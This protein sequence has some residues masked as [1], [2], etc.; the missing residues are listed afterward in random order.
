MRSLLAVT[1]L[2]MLA[3]TTALLSSGCSS[4]GTQPYAGP[5]SPAGT[6]RQVG[7]L[8]LDVVWPARDGTR[9]IPVASESIRVVVTAGET[10]VANRVVARPASGDRTNLILN[11]IPSGTVNVTATAH[12]QGNGSGTAQARGTIAV[13]VQPVQVSRVTL[14]MDSTIDRVLIA[15]DQPEVAPGGT[16]E[17]VATALDA[18]GSLVLTAPSKWTWE[19][20]GA[21]VTV[22]PGGDR[23]SVR[24]DAVG[25]AVVRAKETESAKEGAVTVTVREGAT[26]PGASWPKVRG[27]SRN[28]GHLAGANAPTAKPTA[29]WTFDAGA[30]LTTPP[31]LGSNAVVYF[32]TLTGQV[33]AVRAS[34]G[35]K[36]WDVSTGAG[37]Q[38]ISAPLTLAANGTLYVAASDGTLRALNAANGQQKWSAAVGTVYAGPALSTDGGTLYAVAYTVNGEVLHAVDPAT[39]GVKWTYIIGGVLGVT[40][41]APAL[42]PDGTVY[43]GSASGLLSAVTPGGARRWDA[44]LGQRILAAAP[45]V[46]TDGRVYM[47]AAD[48]FVRAFNGASGQ[49]QWA[50]ATGATVTGTTGSAP[51]VGIGADGYL[52]APGE[53]N[54]VYSLRAETGAKRWGVAPLPGAQIPVFFSAPAIDGRGNALLAYTTRELPTA[55]RVVAMQASDGSVLW[56]FDVENIGNVIR[57][58]DPALGPDGTVYVTSGRKVYALK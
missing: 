40:Q 43:F 51:G 38:G 8:S 35:V 33:F 50:F 3:T 19:K 30:N 5:I 4:G 52:I 39:G 18:A 6:T 14:T 36:V 56:S 55:T 34:D 2:L 15:P 16:I 29:R 23:A 26:N 12:P 25:T 44:A 49:Q 20:E 54:L 42:A 9:L 17:L 37:F 10:T 11:E 7:S 31:I 58:F 47:G 53:D 41:S 48:G 32:G 21:A 27:D 24:G 22:T 28:T 1:T 13:D 57:P 46:G 45:S